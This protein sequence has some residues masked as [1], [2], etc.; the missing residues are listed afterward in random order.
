MGVTMG[1]T[2]FLE[3]REYSSLPFVRVWVSVRFIGVRR[4]ALLSSSLAGSL[5]PFSRYLDDNRIGCIASHFLS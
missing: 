2:N 1:I 4:P 3:I 5:F